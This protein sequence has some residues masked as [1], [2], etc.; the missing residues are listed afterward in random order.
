MLAVA[1][2]VDASGRS[3]SDRLIRISLVIGS[4]MNVLMVAN[5]RSTPTVFSTMQHA[6]YFVAHYGKW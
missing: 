5:G 3:P 6:G 1:R 4:H 2:V